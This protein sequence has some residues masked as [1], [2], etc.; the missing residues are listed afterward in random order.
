MP[1]HSATNCTGELEITSDLPVL[2]AHRTG[3][4]GGSFNPVHFGHVWLARWIAANGGVDDVWLSLSPA[5]PFKNHDSM[6][7]D[8]VRLE[9]LRAAVAHEPLLRVTDVEL[10]LPH[11]S[12]TVDALRVLARENRD[13]AFSLIIGSDNV[14]GFCRWR[15][16]EEI[17]SDF[18]LII[19][20]RPGYD[21]SFPDFLIPYMDNVKLLSGTPSFDIS[22]TEIRRRLLADEPL[23]G[24]LDPAVETILRNYKG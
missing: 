15:R 1:T 14:A 10:S 22:S 13:V 23:D 21:F 7:P 16:W 8:Q 11:P 19:Y 3:V 12:Y 5:S 4:L 9:M 24:F 2:R 17:V 6:L 20:P 18:G